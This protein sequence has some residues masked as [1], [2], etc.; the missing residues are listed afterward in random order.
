[1]KNDIGPV[2]LH[3]WNGWHQSGYVAAI[4]LKQFC[5]YDTKTSLHYWEDC[6]DNWTRGY[7]RI[8]NAI[9]DFEPIDRYRIPK[10]ISDQICP[11]YND[12]RAN[13]IVKNNNDE[14]KSL[15]ISVKFPS[16][17]SDLPPEVSTFLDEYANMLKSTNYLSVE[18]GG[19]TDAKGKNAYNLVLS[20]KR[21]ENVYNYLLKQGVSVNQLTY[22]G[23]GE[24]R[25]LNKCT[26]GIY[27]KDSEHSENRRIEFSITNISYQINFEKGSSKINRKDK[28]VLNDI[29]LILSSDKN[30][31]VE[32]R[33]HADKGTGTDFVND[34]ISHI[35]AETVF[36]YLK[37]NGLDVTNITFKGY[38]S[39]HEKYY[40]KRDRRIEF[41]ITQNE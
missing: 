26:E 36:N 9:R 21:A 6:A 2:Y 4:L 7:D 30:V 34:N 23:Y 18:V 33:G 24:E 22:K 8:R 27:C 41:R 39:L 17:V 29:M 35:R 15:K 37:D 11:C 25:I 3:C 20:E 1:M 14:L 10:E 31:S 38:G 12:D 40:D 32:I 28:Q 19:H 5:G 16:N 13:D